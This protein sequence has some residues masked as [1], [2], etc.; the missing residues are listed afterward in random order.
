MREGE[1][2][3]F[4]NSS[5]CGIC[6]NSYFGGDIKV[7]DHCHISGK[8]RGYVHRDWNINFKLNHKDSVVFHNLKYYDSHLTMHELGKFII[9]INVIPNELGKNYHP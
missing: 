3:Y 1:N 7:R 2:E 4:E 6:D 8:Y 5:K 9:T